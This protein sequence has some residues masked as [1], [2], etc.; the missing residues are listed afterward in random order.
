MPRFNDSDAP[1]W[2]D[3][4]TNKRPISQTQLRKKAQ[5][6]KKFPTSRQTRD[7]LP[8]SPDA[9]S[10][11]LVAPG[12]AL[13]YTRPVSGPASARGPSD[14][15][16]FKGDIFMKTRRALAIALALAVLLGAAA[17]AQTAIVGGKGFDMVK[18]FLKDCRGT[19]AFFIATMDE[20]NQPRVRPFGALAEFEGRLYLCTGKK[21]E[22]YRQIKGNPKVEISGVVN[23]E[24]IRLTTK[25]VEDDR[26][27]AKQAMLD[28][29]PDLKGMYKVDD[30]VFAVLYMTDSQ[31]NILSFTG[32]DDLIRF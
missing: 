7:I 15:I 14:I 32:R 3:I 19:G 31:A 12:R 21:K 20:G 29:N 4:V 30:D 28:Q 18:Q 6:R 22:V 26:R 17:F 5:M 10:K 25:L 11:R 2:L 23:G 24:W 16:F 1:N 9:F 13:A 8:A 27:V